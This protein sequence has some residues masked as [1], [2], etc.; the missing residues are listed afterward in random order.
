VGQKW[1]RGN[2]APDSQK[3]KKRCVICR[4]G[5]ASPHVKS[6]K[7]FWKSA[8]QENSPIKTFRCN[9]RSPHREEAAGW[10][11]LTPA[12]ALLSRIKKPPSAS[13]SPVAPSEGQKGSDSSRNKQSLGAEG[14]TIMRLKIAWAQ[15]IAGECVALRPAWDDEGLKKRGGSEM[16]VAEK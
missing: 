8:V 11:S 16:I 13:G 4:G 15:P 7:K 3:R 1:V 2:E 6:G 9:P 14:C 5:E 10:G 12:E